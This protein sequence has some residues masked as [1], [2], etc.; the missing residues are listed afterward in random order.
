MRPRMYGSTDKYADLTKTCPSAGAGMGALTSVKSDS[1]GNPV[2]R[3]ASW[4]W[5]L[6]LGRA[7]S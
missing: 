6:T 5:R 1:F 2:G 3:A 7:P 4:N